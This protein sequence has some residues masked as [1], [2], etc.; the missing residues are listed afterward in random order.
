MLTLANDVIGTGPRLQMLTVGGE[1]NR[2]IEAEFMAWAKA[3]DLA[4]KLRTMRAARAQDG[5]AFAVLFN[6][7][8][9]DCPVSLDV[10]L[11]EADQVT[12]P[13]LLVPK[14]TAVCKSSAKTAVF[15][16]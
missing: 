7:D 15:T 9:L 16:G 10:R 13:D 12:T 14:K 5:E 4:G 3:I 1:V 6:N 11:I 8:K 2:Q